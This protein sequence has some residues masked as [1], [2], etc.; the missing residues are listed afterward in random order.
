MPQ[1]AI[2]V[3][4]VECSITVLEL[5]DG[6]L[7]YAHIARAGSLPRDIKGRVFAADPNELLRQVVLEVEEA[8]VWFYGN[9]VH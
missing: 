6:A 1:F 7:W 9:A 2:E 4:S 8:V 3:G 5:P